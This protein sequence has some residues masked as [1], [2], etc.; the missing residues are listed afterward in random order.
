MCLSHSG[1]GT[2]TGGELKGK[3]I[4]SISHEKAA[5][6]YQPCSSTMALANTHNSPSLR[7]QLVPRQKNSLIYLRYD[8]SGNLTRYIKGA[9]YQ[10]SNRFMNPSSASDPPSDSS[11]FFSSSGAAAAAAA[12]PPDGAATTA[13]LLGSCNPTQTQNYTITC[14]GIQYV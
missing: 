13:N 6:Y 3:Q 4:I 1:S 11:S 2:S 14:L 7:C 12:P 8:R 10:S 9:A 5:Q